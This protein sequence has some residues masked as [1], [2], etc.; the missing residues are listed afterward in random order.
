M[1]EIILGDYKL[2]VDDR[3]AANI[4]ITIYDIYLHNEKVGD[5]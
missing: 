1:N 5:V 2:L 3:Y 4:S